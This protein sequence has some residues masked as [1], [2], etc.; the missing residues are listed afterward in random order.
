MCVRNNIFLQY[1]IHIPRIIYMK[2]N[3]STENHILLGET[4]GDDHEGDLEK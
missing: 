3:K 2:Y 1:L 4:G